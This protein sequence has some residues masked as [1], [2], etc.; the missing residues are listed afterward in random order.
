[1][2]ASADPV[3]WETGRWPSAPSYRAHPR[4]YHLRRADQGSR[5][6]DHWARADPLQC[7]RTCAI[8][9]NPTS[10]GRRPEFRT[11]WKASIFRSISPCRLALLYASFASA[12]DSDARHCH[13]FRACCS[14]SPIARCGR[15]GALIDGFGRLCHL[16][17]EPRNE[18]GTRRARRRI[19]PVNRVQS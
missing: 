8:H 17:L 10:C 7:T 13:S 11:V 4:L 9:P 5:G 2:T 16:R 14:F 15:D 6:S 18:P 12:L 3:G 19:R 1:M